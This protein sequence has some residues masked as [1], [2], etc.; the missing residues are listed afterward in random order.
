MGVKKSVVTTMR[1]VV[2]QAVDGGVVGGVEAD[3]Q[4]GVA[5][6]VGAEA[7]HEPEHGAQVGGGELAR[8]AR[9][10]REARQPDRLVETRF[11]E[12]RHGPRIRPGPVTAISW[13][14]LRPPGCRTP[15]ATLTTS[16]VC[17]AW[18]IIPPPT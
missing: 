17:G 9:A 14:G 7:A 12:S 15:A 18:I 10:V 2:P 11:V 5:R 13:V 4:V 3:E 8:A 1:E 6:L 16:P